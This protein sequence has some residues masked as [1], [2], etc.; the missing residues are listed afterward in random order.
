[1]Y[2]NSMFA[3]KIA[4]NDK[5]V[6]NWILRW[7]HKCKKYSPSKAR[8]ANECNQCDRWL[9]I[10]SVLFLANDGHLAQC[11]VPA[12]SHGATCVPF[13]TLLWCLPWKIPSITYLA[14]EDAGGMAI[15]R[16]KLVGRTWWPS[17]EWSN[18]AWPA[19]HL[20]L[21]LST[22][23]WL[24]PQ[25]SN[26]GPPATAQVRSCVTPWHCSATQQQ[27]ESLHQ[28]ALC[29]FWWRRCC[30]PLCPRLTGS[31]QPSSLSP[32]VA[33]H[34]LL[35]TVNPISKPLLWGLPLVWNLNCINLSP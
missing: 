15:S 34:T 11:Q 20:R 2:W 29:V 17:S 7:K 1:M 28:S 19:P 31:G 18:C 35:G 30:T 4:P 12:C 24:C 27:C 33:T 10:L 5:C 23:Q 9:C 26:S 22:V 14:M 32:G 6:L 25:L 16:W 21:L 13:P 8:A 3:M